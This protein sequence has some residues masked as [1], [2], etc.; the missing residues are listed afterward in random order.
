MMWVKQWNKRLCSMIMCAVLMAAT[1][2]SSLP[3]S[4]AMAENDGENYSLAAGEGSYEEYLKRYADVLPLQ[5]KTA[6]E[7]IFSQKGDEA[8]WH[9]AQ[10]GGEQ[11]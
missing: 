1:L 11:V 5:E 2:S 3:V 7:I 9:K 10:D 6:A 4:V 8:S